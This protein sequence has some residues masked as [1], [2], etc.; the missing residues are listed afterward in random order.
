MLRDLVRGDRCNLR[1]KPL[2]VSDHVAESGAAFVRCCF[3]HDH[4]LVMVER[5]VR[6]ARSLE[7]PDT[8]GVRPT[9]KFSG[10][11]TYRMRAQRATDNR[12]S[13]ATQR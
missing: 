8:F 11:R 1:A 13:A 12:L 2:C 5:S 3:L 9:P 10:K 4:R 7:G 6:V